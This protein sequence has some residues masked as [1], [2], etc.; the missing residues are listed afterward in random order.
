MTKTKLHY[1]RSMRINVGDYEGITPDV[2][3]EIEVDVDDP[4]TDGKKIFEE[5]KKTVDALFWEE[6]IRQIKDIMSIRMQNP[7]NDAEKITNM[8][9][10]AYAK[11]QQI[12]GGA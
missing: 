1:N 4:E 11:L 3:M 7:K 12:K 5:L 8:A 6:V 9:N 2:G 10:W